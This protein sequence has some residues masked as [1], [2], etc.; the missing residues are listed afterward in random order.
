MRIQWYRWCRRWRS[1][2]SS[3]WLCQTGFARPPSGST[4]SSATAAA[5]TMSVSSPQ[6]SPLLLRA[7][8][9]LQMPIKL[10]ACLS[11]GVAGREI[12]WQALLMH[13]HHKTSA[14]GADPRLVE[15]IATV[16]RAWAA[17]RRRFRQRGVRAPRQLLLGHSFGLVPEPMSRNPAWLQPLRRALRAVDVKGLFPRLDRGEGAPE[18]AVHQALLFARGCRAPGTG[19]LGDLFADE[20]WRLVLSSAPRHWLSRMGSPARWRTTRAAVLIP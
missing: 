11:L 13:L 14:P 10:P 1:T 2:S 3:S 19:P 17:I 7:G 9:R 16:A 8:G 6:P 20:R 18:A 5:A 15:D 12:S 4:R